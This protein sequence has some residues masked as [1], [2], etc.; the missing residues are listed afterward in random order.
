MMVPVVRAELALVVLN[1]A[2]MDVDVPVAPGTPA[3]PTP[4][5]ATTVDVPAPE[6]P[7]AIVA[8]A[9]RAVPASAVAPM[10]N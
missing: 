3:L 2:A 8:S 5:I 6:A 4:M 9:G 1:M 7:A 10:A